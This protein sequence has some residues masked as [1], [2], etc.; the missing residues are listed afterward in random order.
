M[1]LRPPAQP[2]PIRLELPRKLVDAF[3]APDG[4]WRYSFYKI[5]YGGRGSAKSESF[6]RLLIAYA[7]SKRGRILCARQYMNSIADSVYKTIVDAIFEMGI[8]DEFDILETSITHR[9]SGTDFIFKGFQRSIGEIKSMKGLTLC[10]VEEAETVTAEAW[11]VLEPTMRGSNEAEIWVAFNPESENSPIYQR[12]VVKPRPGDIVVEMNWR[13]NPWFPAILEMQR[14]QC[15]EFDPDNYDWIWEG[16]LRKIADAQVFKSRWY[17]EDF[18]EPDGI[19]PLYGLDF[20]FSND[21]TAGVRIFE[22]AGIGYTDLYISH[23][24]GGYRVE[25]DEI[26]RLLLGTLLKDQ[27]LPDVKRYPLKADSARP[28]TISYLKRNGLPLISAAEKWPGSVEDGISHMKGYRR[29]VIHT[30]CTRTAFEFRNY[31]HK[32]DKKL[33]DENGK[34]AVLPDIEDANN[35]YIDAIRYALDGRIGGRKGARF[36]KGALSQIRGGR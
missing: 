12:A 4:Q 15:L 27:V 6:A 16:K 28:E 34:P 17:V 29:I 1:R 3:Y 10:F 20:G 7:R 30:R 31:S 14:L 25:N 33:L 23:E 21:P 24:A 2:A 32:I 9:V 11:L 13:D 35:H 18:D 8:Q 26:E 22:V 36:G 19:Q 5:L